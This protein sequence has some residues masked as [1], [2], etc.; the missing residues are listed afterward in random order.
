MVKILTVGRKRETSLR[1]HTSD[2][3][4]RVTSRAEVQFVHHEYDFR[5]SQAID[6]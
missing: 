2:K 1:N 5:K 6:N 4:N 3:Q